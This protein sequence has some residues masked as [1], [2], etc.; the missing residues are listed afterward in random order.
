VRVV[1]SLYAQQLATAAFGVFI[2]VVPLL[3][4]NDSSQSVDG[5]EAYEQRSRIVSSVT[6]VLG[7]GI[8]AVSGFLARRRRKPRDARRLEP[9][10]PER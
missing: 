4:G 7:V 10:A 3:A 1:S 5:P 8:L 2:L 6:T 9:P